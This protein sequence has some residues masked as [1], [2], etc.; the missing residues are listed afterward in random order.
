LDLKEVREGLLRIAKGGKF[1]HAF[2]FAGP[3]GTGKTSAARIFAKVVNCQNPQDGEPCNKCDACQEI[4]KGT[5][6]DLIE[7]D[8]A[9]NRGIDDIRALRETI[10]L[11]PVKLKYKVYIIDEV[12]MLTLEAFNALLKT[13]EEPPPHAIFILC[14][15][16]PDKLPETII[17]RC[18]RFNFRKA[19]IEEIIQGPLR[20]SVESEGLEVEKG[21]LEEIAKAAGGSFRD[22]HKILEEL[23]AGGK[24]ITLKQTR[25]LLGQIEELS[26]EKLL[27]FL[28]K[29]DAKGGLREIAR[30]VE[31]GVDLENYLLKL[32][33]LLRKGLLE[34]MGVG[35]EPVEVLKNFDVSQIK[36]LISL[37]SRAAGELRFSPIPQLP[38][39]LAV[40]EWC[41]DKMSNLPAG[42][43]GFKTQMS[44]LKEKKSSPQVQ[45]NSDPQAQ[46]ANI[47]RVEEKWAEILTKIK[48]QNHSVEAL[49]KATRIKDF[50]NGWLTLE[51]F[52]KFHK[53]RLE[54]EKCRRIVEETVG[55]V[56]GTPV[57]LKC[58]LGEKKNNLTI[59]Q[60]NNE[61]NEE[62]DILEVANEIFNGKI[63]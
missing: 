51:V 33:E 28:E 2:L 47:K 58:I 9:S 43:A 45:Q 63:E 60:S 50:Q 25:Q 56:I 12:H 54:T 11:S 32:L 6:M 57:K 62:I 13:L 14:T 29:K 20:R 59:Q 8:A 53:E 48:P 24:K 38:L 26:A 19:K 10:K 37:F 30:V 5:A 1:P 36:S 22:A 46:A 16:E 31:G 35:E 55:K 39:E 18:L 61:N 7:I 42:Q 27:P 49:L 23:A 44:N 52:Y 21:V 3:K 4:T 41:G 40:V 17:S 15:T 34:K